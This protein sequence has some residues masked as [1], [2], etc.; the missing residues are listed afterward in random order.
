MR[1]VPS[2]EQN[3]LLHHYALCAKIYCMMQYKHA[4]RTMKNWTDRLCKKS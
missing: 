4:K 3:S 1:S 2:V